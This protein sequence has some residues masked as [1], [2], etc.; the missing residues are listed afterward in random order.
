MGIRRKH[1]KFFL[2][3]LEILLQSR[4]IADAGAYIN[5]LAN[6]NSEGRVMLLNQ[7]QESFF[8]STTVKHTS[9]SFGLV[10]SRYEI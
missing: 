6:W 4:I 1:S 3:A 8:S 7:L 2:L 5:V 9:C 10:F